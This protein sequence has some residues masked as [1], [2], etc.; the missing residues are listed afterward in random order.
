MV[1]ILRK[2]DPIGRIFCLKAKNRPINKSYSRCP[3]FKWQESF[4]IKNKNNFYVLINFI[5]GNRLANET[6]LTPGVWWTNLVKG[7]FSHF[8]VFI[9]NTKGW[10]LTVWHILSLTGNPWSCLHNNVYF[11]NILNSNVVQHTQAGKQC[12]GSFWWIS[13][14][15]NEQC[16]LWPS[17]GL[18]YPH[19]WLAHK[20]RD[21]L[22]THY[23]S[24]PIV[25]RANC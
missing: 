12:G 9:F 18:E 22:Y 24:W 3:T 23:I 6:E 2:R 1:I 20:D 19:Y 11:P 7:F 15:P 4:Q 5:N 17:W 21:P 13:L 25:A 8:Q 16:C 14:G 10:C